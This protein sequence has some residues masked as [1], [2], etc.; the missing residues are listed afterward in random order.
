M[1]NYSANGYIIP[2]AIASWPANGNTANG[3]ATNLA[4][5]ADL[6]LNDI[7]EPELGEHPLIRGDEAL[8]VIFN[9]DR[10]VHTESGGDKIG[11]EIHLMLYA[12]ANTGEA[13]NDQVVFSHYEIYNRSQSNNFSSFY[14]SS[15]IDF[16]IGSGVDDYIGTNTV[17]NMIYAY[18]G[19]PID[20][21]YGSNPPAYGYI[22]LNEPL[23]HS[24]YYNNNLNAQN[25]S[26]VLPNEYYNYMTGRWKDGTVLLNPSDSTLIDFIFP[27]DSDTLN[28]PNWS[29]VN[30]GNLPSDRRMLGSTYVQNFGSG[31]KICLDYASIFAHDNTL[32]H[33]EQL[34]HL[35][36]LG[37]DVQSFYNSQYDDCSDL[38]DLNLVELT[39]TDEN[40][41][42]ITQ[43]S[44]QFT[45]NIEQSLKSDLHIYVVDMLGRTV[46]QGQLNQG[47]T[48]L[49]FHIPERKT[50]VFVIRCLNTEVN[51]SIKVI[52]NE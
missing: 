46:F 24:M 44:N 27:G 8:F 32:D 4:P 47:E 37:S 26:P 2:T 16:D 33:I 14:V 31:N 10:S 5:Y 52:V 38:S 23:I 19:F 6:N 17:E 30:A 34:D 40:N 49:S 15:W 12:Y 9:D 28:Y 50:K 42:S 11:V 1:A 18:N 35:F 36:E 21:D 29:E 22:L 20:A 13:N 45:L 7:Y 48:T 39:L 3:E 25:G 43:V 41:L 51:E